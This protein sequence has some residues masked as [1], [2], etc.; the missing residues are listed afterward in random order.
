VS[1]Q[2]YKKA[3]I[4]IIAFFL[5]PFTLRSQQFFRIKADFS[6]KELSAQNTGDRLT[7]GTLFYDVVSEKLVMD[8]SFPEK[9]TLVFYDSL[10][11]T[12]V[13][14]QIVNQSSLFDNFISSSVYHLILNNKLQ[15]FGLA[16]NQYYQKVDIQE[17]EGK[18]I[19]EW[20]PSSTLKG[21]TGKILTLNK[22][23]ILEAIIFYDK[24]G[25]LLSKQNFKDYIFVQ[26]LNI[27]SEIIHQYFKKENIGS[28]KITK[29][30]S[31]KNIVL[32]EMQNNSY[33]NYNIP[34]NSK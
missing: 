6:I 4:V 10:V 1:I 30:Y 3:I 25:N 2:N 33:Y 13:N 17:Q 15:N 8:I 21:L 18:I 22:G 7:T 26:G 9:E 16:D 20:N 24:E 19:T 29:I 32:N 27:P 23:N 12:I 31:Y 34:H 11:Y 14:D 28:S 5:L